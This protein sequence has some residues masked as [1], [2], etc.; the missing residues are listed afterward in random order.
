MV[1]RKIIRIDEKK[2]N[3]CG[4]CIPNC[5][6]GA[7]KVINGKLKLTRDIF[8]DGLGACIGHC[9][10]EAITIIERNA[11]PYNEKIVMGHIARE[12]KEAIKAHLN[13]L[14]DH[15]EK[16]Y[17]KQAIEFLNERKIEY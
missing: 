4:I 16:E 8:C 7:L 1:K 13:H 9:P 2:C 3:G 15:N 5:P 14:K 11:E 17:L 10:Q 6:E 12:G